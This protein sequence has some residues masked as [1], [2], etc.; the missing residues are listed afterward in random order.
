MD[1]L[2]VAGGDALAV[3]TDCGVYIMRL[4]APAVWKKIGDNLPNAPVFDLWYDA[5]DNVLAATLLGR[6]A[7][8]WDLTFKRT[9]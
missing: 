8:T 3:G 6:G 1:Y 2:T 7:W 4:C 5:T 9:L